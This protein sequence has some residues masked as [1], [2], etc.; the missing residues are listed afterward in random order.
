LV[1]PL[2]LFNFVSEP[3]YIKILFPSPNELFPDCRFFPHKIGVPSPTPQASVS[4]Q[5]MHTSSFSLALESSF[6]TDAT[7]NLPLLKASITMIVPLS[8][9]HQVISLKFTNNNYIYLRMQM[10]PYLLGQVIF[11]FFDGS[12]SCPLSHVLFA[13]DS[14]FR[15]IL[16]FFIRRSM[17]NLFSM[18]CFLLFQWMYCI[19]LSIAKPCN[20]FGVLLTKPSFPRLILV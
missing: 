19:L 5:S 10:K 6:A 7:V 8:N 18:H 20:V 13:D 1:K 15:L 16:F 14:F 2:V 12:L 9:T 11:H 4:S 3:L 17:I